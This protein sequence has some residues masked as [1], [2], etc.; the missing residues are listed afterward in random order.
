MRIDYNYINAVF[1]AKPL[2]NTSQSKIRW[3][4]NRIDKR[5]E[6]KIEKKGKKGRDTVKNTEWRWAVIDRAENK[7]V[8]CGD[9]Q[10]LEAHHINAYHS[11]PSIR[12]DVDNGVA[13]CHEHHKKFHKMFSNYNSC[14]KQWRIFLSL[15]E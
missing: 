9:D 7:C 3:N 8:I 2:K 10:R 11:N 12:Y 14:E 4:R 5:K 1:N 13:L 15:F 6:F